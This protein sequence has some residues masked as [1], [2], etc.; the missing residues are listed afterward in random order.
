VT[1]KRTIHKMTCITNC[2]TTNRTPTAAVAVMSLIT[3]LLVG[4][5]PESEAF[6]ILGTNRNSRIQHWTGTCPSSSFL[7]PLSRTIVKTSL[8]AKSSKRSGAA[9]R[10]SNA[11]TGISSNSSGGSSGTGFGQQP[12]SIANQKQTAKNDM[13]RQDAY[14]IYSR[15]AMYDLAFGYR[16]YEEEVKFLLDVHD[17][18]CQF[19]NDK[20]GNE[21]DV[22][23]HC[24]DGINVIE[25]AAGP[26]RHGVT[27]LKNF[28]KRVNSCTAV[29]VSKE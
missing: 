8:F 3:F 20:D 6:T 4:P 29:D 5:L 23:E 17:K 24:N 11:K 18:Y 9:S 22:D 19:K 14:E 26:A 21:H 10:R 1:E 15:P 27:A 28:Q 2:S 25:L 12:S 7:V 13:V 16:N